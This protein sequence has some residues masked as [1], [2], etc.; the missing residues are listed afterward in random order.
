MTADLLPLDI[1]SLVVNYYLMRDI[2]SLFP[3]DDPV[4]PDLLIGRAE[5]VT[6]VGERLVSGTHVILAGPRRTGK[7]TVAR[8]ALRLVSQSGAYTAAADLFDH[9]DAGAL[10]AAVAQ[11]VLANRG[12][13]ARALQRARSTGRQLRDLVSV[14]VTAKLRAELGDG[15]Q[16]ALTPALARQHPRGALVGALELAETIAVK[17]SKPMVVF[18]D[19]F[20]EIAG[21]RR[22]FG[23]LDVVTKQLRAVL[24]R[25]PH[26]TVMFAGS[27]E[28]LMRDLFGPARRALSQFGTFQP[29]SPITPD[30]WHEGLAKRYHR[31]SV[32]VPE[33]TTIAQIASLGGGHPRATMLIARETLAVALAAHDDRRVLSSDVDLGFALA[34][35]AD[36]LRHQQAVERMRLTKHA[37]EIATRVARGERPYPGRAPAAAHR[38]LRALELQGIIERLARGHWVVGDPLLRHYLAN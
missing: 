31:L 1:T 17:D 23:D 10:A 33:N 19:E 6:S 24:Q 11:A 29:L 12:Q 38:A 2:R 20:Q 13:I 26:V 16:L 34:M 15:V 35:E 36:R 9:D 18:L 37:H 5:D 32:S 14:S 27:V 25:S 7:T 8:A 30:E 3:T 28:H 4:D 21:D 22:R